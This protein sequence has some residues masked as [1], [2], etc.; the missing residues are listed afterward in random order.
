MKREVELLEVE[1]AHVVPGGRNSVGAVYQSKQG[2]G[3]SEGVE[4]RKFECGGDYWTEGG[5]KGEG[6]D[7]WERGL[8][9]E[10]ELPAYFR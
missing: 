2:L 10:G 6:D 8:E 9:Q 4:E 7:E 1:A 5:E 3:V